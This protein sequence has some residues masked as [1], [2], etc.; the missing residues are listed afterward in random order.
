MW[1]G[2]KG[3]GKG[4]DDDD[5]HD[6]IMMV[7]MVTMRGGRARLPLFFNPDIVLYGHAS[8]LVMCMLRQ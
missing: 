6:D 8:T 1:V 4:D 2:H 5:D 3:G 7:M